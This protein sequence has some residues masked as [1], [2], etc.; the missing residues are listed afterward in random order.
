MAANQ[1]NGLQ[2]GGNNPDADGAEVLHFAGLADGRAAQMPAELESLTPA[3]L[4]QPST[5]LSTF[6]QFLALWTAFY[7]T[8]IVKAH[9]SQAGVNIVVTFFGT[10]TPENL[11]LIR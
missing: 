9:P 1:G 3:E 2:A 7:Q 8:L 5:P 4:T 11:R 10:L 6:D